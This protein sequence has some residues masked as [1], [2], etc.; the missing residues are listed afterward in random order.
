MM[1][2]T[3]DDSGLGECSICGRLVHLDTCDSTTDN[4]PLCDRCFDAYWAAKRK[5]RN[6]E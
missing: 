1:A 4:K 2:T 6:E 5:E 3:P